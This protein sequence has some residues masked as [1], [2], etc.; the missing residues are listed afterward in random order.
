MEKQIEK[1]MDNKMEAGVLQGC[2]GINTS[3]LVQRSL[4][5]SRIGYLN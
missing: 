5:N 2:I 3:T 1:T 4:S